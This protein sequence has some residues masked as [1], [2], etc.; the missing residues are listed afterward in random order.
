MNKFESKLKTYFEN[1]PKWDGKTDY[2]KQLSETV[3]VNNPKCFNETLKK[4]LIATVSC[5]ELDDSVNDVCLVINGNQGIGKSMWLRKLAP[6]SFKNDYVY[7]GLFNT[8]NKDDQ[9]LLTER[10][11][12]NL[13]E[14]EYKNKTQLAGLK[15][16][17][18]RQR[19][20]LRKAYAKETTTHIRRASFIG[21]IND[22]SNLNNITENRRW[23]V[24]TAISNID[25]NHNIDMDKVWAQAYSLFMKGTRCW[26]D[27]EEINNVNK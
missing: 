4:F 9:I 27:N 7:E 2:I 23:L 11:F 22:K 25:Y 15:T 26:F 13:D 17:I 3:P 14:L 12:I 10:W 8:S 20:S 19:I 16:C 1:L 6:E 5:L 18:T 21:S 24:F